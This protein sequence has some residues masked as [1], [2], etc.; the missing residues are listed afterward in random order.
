MANILQ[1]QLD[2]ILL[3][4]CAAILPEQCFE[5]PA[6]QRLPGEQIFRFQ[7]F[8]QVGVDKVKHPGNDRMLA[9]IKVTALAGNDFSGGG[10]GGRGG[11]S[12]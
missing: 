4:R 11:V 9:E 1:A 10:G 3:R 6:L 5:G 8:V 7:R 2:Q 12:P